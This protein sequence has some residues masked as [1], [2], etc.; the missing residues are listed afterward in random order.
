MDYTKQKLLHMYPLYQLLD[1]LLK[2]DV[3]S[4]SFFLEMNGSQL[5]Q[6]RLT[7]YYHRLLDGNF[8]AYITPSVFC[9]LTLCSWY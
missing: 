7:N 3:A 5:Q 9:F 8:S 2:F 1:V 6:T 4:K